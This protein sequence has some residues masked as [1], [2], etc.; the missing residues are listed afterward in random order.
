VRPDILLEHSR[1]LPLVSLTI[2]SKNGGLHDPPGQEG[3]TRI[4]ARLMRRTGGGR[5]PQTIDTLV[6]SIGT[7]C[8]E[9]PE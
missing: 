5:D 2:A 8:C 7:A 1:D 6:D 9:S 3:L 4:V